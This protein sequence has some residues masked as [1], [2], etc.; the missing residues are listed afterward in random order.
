MTGGE[1]ANALETFIHME[2]RD[3]NTSGGGIDNAAE[4]YIDLV[5]LNAQAETSS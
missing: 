3:I 1:A 2:A 4:W 5:G